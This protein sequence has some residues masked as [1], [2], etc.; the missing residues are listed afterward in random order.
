MPIGGDVGVLEGVPLHPPM[1]PKGG[2]RVG[3]GAGN[4]V[5]GEGELLCNHDIVTP[6]GVTM[7]TEFLPLLLHALLV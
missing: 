7:S 3:F 1:G 6:S 2:S 5:W 4:P